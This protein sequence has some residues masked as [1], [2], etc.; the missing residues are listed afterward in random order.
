MANAESGKN[1]GVQERYRAM[2]D[3][4]SSAKGGAQRAAKLM[5]YA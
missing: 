4:K 1:G 5:A 2:A 3:A